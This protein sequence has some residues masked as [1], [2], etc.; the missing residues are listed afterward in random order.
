M[1]EEFKV[2]FVK[3]LLNEENGSLLVKAFEVRM[4]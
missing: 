2:F 4:T 1:G 3:P